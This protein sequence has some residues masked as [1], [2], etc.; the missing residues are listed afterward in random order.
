MTDIHHKKAE[1]AVRK[2]EQNRNKA[3]QKL[4][5]QRQK[6]AERRKKNREQSEKAQGHTGDSMNR[7]PS[8]YSTVPTQKTNEQNA[9]RNAHSTV[10][11]APRYSQISPSERLFGLRFY[12]A[13][14]STNSNDGK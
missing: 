7:N 13:K 11:T 4:L 1:Q 3:R 5:Q 9:A 12:R 8:A 14:Q 10:P 6:L 2:A